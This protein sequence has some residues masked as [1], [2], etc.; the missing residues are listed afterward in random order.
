MVTVT[1]G[2]TL[3]F[4]KYLG[5]FKSELLLSDIEPN[6]TLLTLKND[7]TPKGMIGNII[8]LFFK[9]KFKR[10]FLKTFI[11]LKNLIEKENKK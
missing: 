9:W 6:K 11:G 3:D 2:G 10:Q 8:N 1:S 7:Y 5:G 4:E